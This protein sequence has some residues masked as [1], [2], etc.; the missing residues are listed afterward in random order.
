MIAQRNLGIYNC[1]FVETKH[2]DVKRN[3]K[4]TSIAFYNENG[5]IFQT[6]LGWIVHETV[7]IKGFKCDEPVR[8]SIKLNLTKNDVF[9]IWDK[10]RDIYSNEPGY[11]LY[12]PERLVGIEVLPEYLY[13][14]HVLQLNYR[15]HVKLTA[16][17]T[18]EFLTSH[19]N[20]KDTPYTSIKKIESFYSL[21]TELT[22]DGEL[23]KKL[24]DEFTGLRNSELSDFLSKYNVTKK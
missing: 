17:D 18:A 9:I 3:A 23:A 1:Y 4:I 15:T 19:I 13:S 2:N 16:L 12:I 24:Q 14:T 5:V 10:T 22:E 21:R 11:T 6:Q 20:D 8:T 7:K